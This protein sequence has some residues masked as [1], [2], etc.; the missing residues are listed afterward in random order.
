MYVI[1]IKHKFE[2]LVKIT[3]SVVKNYVYGCSRKIDHITS[4]N[5]FL[6]TLL[7]PNTKF[8]D[9]M[10]CTNSIISISGLTGLINK[11]TESQQNIN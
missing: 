9:F 11:T 7:H 3:I 6:K 5:F 2:I 8:K 10:R 1:S 4:N